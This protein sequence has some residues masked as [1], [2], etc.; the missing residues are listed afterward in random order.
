MKIPRIVGNR[1]RILNKHNTRSLKHRI[2]LKFT[3]SY[4]KSIHGFLS[5]WTDIIKSKPSNNVT[6]MFVHPSI[7][8]KI[9]NV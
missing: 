5:E 8:E 2:T 1:R 4:N 9:N 3:E 7:Q 6:P